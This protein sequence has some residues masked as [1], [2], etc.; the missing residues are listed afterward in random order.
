MAKVS[1]D[2]IIEAAIRLFNINGY[3]ATSMQDIA[4]AVCIK[5]PSLYH[6]FDSK[7]AILLSILDTG[8][9]WLITEVDAIVESEMDCV[10]KLRA[11]VHAHA[12]M[13]ARNPEGAAVFLREDRGLGDGY[14]SQYVSRRDH[15]ERVIRNIVKQGIN[16]GVFRQTDT[17]ISVN[18]LLG[19]VNWMT[20]W[21]R[22]DGRLSP[23]EIADQ[24]ADL[25]LFGL[26]QK[27]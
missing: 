24:F 26:L 23:V 10:A 5:K 8:M 18:A 1:R 27:P 2:E 14:L 13:I 6:H 15:F 17:T 12:T 25:F 4:K 11:A 21:Y 20:R 7:E 3:H 19:T 16:E 22:P 9:E